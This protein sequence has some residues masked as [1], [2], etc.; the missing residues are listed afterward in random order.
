MT[1]VEFPVVETEIADRKIEGVEAFEANAIDGGFGARTF[2]LGVVRDFNQG[3][4]VV[5]VSYDALVPLAL[6]VFDEIAREAARKWAT[7]SHIK[8]IHRIGRLGVGDASLLI[9]VETPHRSE[10]YAISRY[11]LEEIKKRAPIWKKEHYESGDSEW[12]QGHALC[13]S[14]HDREQE[15]NHN[16]ES[17]VHP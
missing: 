10:G 5:A 15:H 8:I 17:G 3:K 16:H 6:R 12:L 14:D 2:F 11:V 1:A 9:L 13:G 4:R 7:R